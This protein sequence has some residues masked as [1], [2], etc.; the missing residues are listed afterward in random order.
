VV[1]LRAVLISSLFIRLHPGCSGYLCAL[2]RKALTLC[3]SAAC[4]AS[5]GSPAQVG[6]DLRC[7]SALVAMLLFTAAAVRHREKRLPV[8]RQLVKWSS[9]CFVRLFVRCC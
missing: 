4:S 9:G 3:R 8:A 1:Y 6:H 7:P 5:S 2:V